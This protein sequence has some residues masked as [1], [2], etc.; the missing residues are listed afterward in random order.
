M[1][2][3]K[4]RSKSK[5]DLPVKQELV[6]DG[7][8]ND[9]ATEIVPMDK[10]SSTWLLSLQLAGIAVCVSG[11]FSG[12]ALAKG[13]G[14]NDV[15][16]ATVVGN[17]IGALIGGLT[18]AIGSKLGLSTTVISRRSFGLR[19]S[20]A[21]SLMAAITLVGWY[22]VQVGFF[23]STINALAPNLGFVTSIEGAALIGGLLMMTTAYFGYR[24]I[25]ILSA[26]AV[27]VLF[28]TAFIGLYKAVA[29][30]NFGV[31]IPAESFSLAQGITMTVGSFAVGAVLLS[32]ITRYAKSVTASWIGT[33]ACFLVANTFI[34]L[35]GALTFIATN[36]GDLPKAM[37]ALGMG[38][39]ALL[40]LILAQWTTNDNNLYS[41]SLAISNIS[42]AKKKNVVLVLGL[43]A[44][45]IGVAGVAEQLTQ[46]LIYLGVLIPP[47]AGVIIADFWI[48]KRKMEDCSLSQWNPAAFIAWII[49]G[50]SGFL[51]N[52]GIPSVNSILVA[53]VV[54]LLVDRLSK[55]I[56]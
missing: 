28:V 26:I 14:L 3:I 5:P 21:V 20:L 51:I 43:I 11:L 50:T 16:L 10:R 48:L 38:A 42:K 19:G 8:G 7:L 52:W 17:S 6:I 47:V 46:W 15:I 4:P 9:F 32:D 30:T 12:A 39:P 35:A 13:L 18:G 53:L 36:S 54:Y 49:G 27:P 24:G 29:T 37:L 55:P 44:T 22:A 33:I 31:Y 34:M 23:G 41:A 56:E 25:A 40:V 1:Q 45:L 2:E